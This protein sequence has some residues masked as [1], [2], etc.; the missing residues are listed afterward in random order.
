MDVNKIVST[1]KALEGELGTHPST[2]A[3]ADRAGCAEATALKYLQRAVR[4]GQVVQREG[5]Y[6]TPDVAEAF[7]K[8]KG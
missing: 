4:A 1:L 2:K 5:R 3:V 7:K 8:Q 6:M